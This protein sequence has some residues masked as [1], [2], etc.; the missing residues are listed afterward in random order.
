MRSGRG[1]G[2]RKLVWARQ[3]RYS[4]H[5]HPGS[6]NIFVCLPSLFIVPL[7]LKVETLL[8]DEKK[9]KWEGGGK[10]K[11]S[12]SASNW[13]CSGGGAA[14]HN[15]SNHSEAKMEIFVSELIRQGISHPQITPPPNN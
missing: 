2:R 9:N 14:P 5:L 4:L 15:E 1:Q 13:S 10:K 7:R 8:A 6:L 3:Q 11:K 12:L